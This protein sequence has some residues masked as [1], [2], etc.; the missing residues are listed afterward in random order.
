M[1]ATVIEKTESWPRVNMRFQK[2]KNYKRKRSKWGKLPCSRPPGIAPSPA[3][4]G[5]D[6]H[7]PSESPG[8]QQGQRVGMALSPL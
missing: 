8:D 3:L 7:L 1:E 6:R 4:G 2:R 5:S